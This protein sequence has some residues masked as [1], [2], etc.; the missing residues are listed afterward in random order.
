MSQ[1]QDIELLPITSPNIEQFSKFLSQVTL[2][3]KFT[4]K[5]HYH[6]RFHHTLMASLHYLVKY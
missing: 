6:Y 4:M 2:T 5:N 3:G 1:K